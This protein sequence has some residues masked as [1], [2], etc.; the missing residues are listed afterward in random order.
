MGTRNLVCGKFHSAQDSY[1]IVL[2]RA[3]KGL[4][5]TLIKL[6]FFSLTLTK[7]WCYLPRNDNMGKVF[8]NFNYQN[9]Y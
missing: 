3:L 4:P 9:P 6:R 5:L 2:W 1:L 7:T 8:A